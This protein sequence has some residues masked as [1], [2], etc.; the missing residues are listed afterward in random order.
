MSIAAL[1]VIFL[2]F[3]A[4]L[5]LSH[6][7]GQSPSAHAEG[8]PTPK[9]P[10][11]ASQPAVGKEDQ[12]VLVDVPMEKRE[13]MGIR[14]VAAGIKSFKKTLR[15]VGRVE[16]NERKLTT[17]N[18]KVEGWIE[19]LHADYTGK[20]VRKGTALAEVYSPELI[21]LQLEYLNLLTMQS[22]V[23]FRSQRNVEFS[24]GDRYGTVGR[25]TTYD[26]EPLFNVAKQKFALWEISDEQIKELEKTKKPMKT[27]T[28]KSP[29]DGYVFQKPVFEGTRVA[30]GDKLFDIVDLSTVWI[31]ADI[32]EYELPFVKVG[33]KAKITLSYYPEKEF[34]AR[35][36]FIYPSLSGQ[37]RTAKARFVL[38]NPQ[39]LL[40]P[41]MFVDVELELDLGRRLVIPETALL[42][43]GTRQV[44]YVDRGDGAFAA[45]QIKAGHRANGMVEVLS[46]LKAGEKVASSAVFLIDSEAKLKGVSQ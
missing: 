31:Q 34:Q 14:T 4:Y 2:V 16:I 13:M 8:K 40:K 12:G 3:A 38:P 43:T 37:T 17:V 26:L 33:Q 32:Y 18:I 1:S 7:A 39:G 41:Q 23:G 20:V 9:D 5:L 10:S 27:L 36:D 28:I 24:W 6:P 22:S 30:P 42:S 25:V 15:T 29:T 11:K 21:S 19:K 44:V 45:R 35:V 46:G